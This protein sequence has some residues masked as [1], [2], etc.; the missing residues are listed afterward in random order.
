MRLIIQRVFLPSKLSAPTSDDFIVFVMLIRKPGKKIFEECC[1]GRASLV[2]MTI[3][4]FLLL[5][6]PPLLQ[7]TQVTDRDFVVKFI[8]RCASCD[9]CAETLNGG[10]SFAV[11]A[12]VLGAAFFQ[13]GPAL[14]RNP[15]KETGATVMVPLGCRQFH[16][17]KHEHSLPT[18]CAIYSRLM[19]TF[20]S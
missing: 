3:L 6:F 7:Q 20:N 17:C 11:V 2:K 16:V 19:R 14:V 9:L 15:G 8:T 1:W 10:P 5:L 12:P 4:K 18:S 13:S